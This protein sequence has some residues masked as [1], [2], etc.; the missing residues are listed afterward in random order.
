MLLLNKKQIYKPS[1]R[2]LRRLFERSTSFWDSEAWTET[3]SDM[4]SARVG[5]P[6]FFKC[7]IIAP[8]TNDSIQQKINIR[9]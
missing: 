6:S 2:T 7:A 5:N 8:L 1:S 4:S 9:S 3:T